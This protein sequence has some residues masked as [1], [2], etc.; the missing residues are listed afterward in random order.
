MVTDVLATYESYEYHKA[1][2]SVMPQED[3]YAENELMDIMRKANEQ[4]K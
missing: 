4:N 3:A 2:G 1:N